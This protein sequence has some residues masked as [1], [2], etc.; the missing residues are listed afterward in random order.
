P[1]RRGVGGAFD[2]WLG[3]RGRG[4][5]LAGAGAVFGSGERAADAGEQDALASRARAADGGDGGGGV[6]AHGRSTTPDRS[7]VRIRA[8]VPGARRV[9]G[10]DEADVARRL[11][12]RELCPGSVLGE[13]RV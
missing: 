4:R 13:A 6:D 7:G 9:C 10:G 2:G 12:R 1:L 11:L 3:G 8:G 5:A